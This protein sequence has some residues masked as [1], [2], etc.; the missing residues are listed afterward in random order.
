MDA[1]EAILTRRSIRRYKSN[2]VSHDQIK[3]LIE[4]GMSAPN[5]RNLQ[6]WYFAVIEK[7]E[8]LD[9]VISFH[10]YAGMLKEAHCAILVCGNSKSESTYEYIIQNCSAATE[11]ILLAAHVM[12]LG[13][14]WLGICPRKPRMDGIRELLHIPEHII[15]VSLIAIGYPAE[16]KTRENRYDEKKVIYNTW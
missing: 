7:R 9:S 6:P 1:M 10:K 16:A 15:P 5:V 13:T 2:P 14:C 11:N 4:A 8:L 3:T 12:S